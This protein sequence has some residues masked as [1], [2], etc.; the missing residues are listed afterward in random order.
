M[1]H[2][3]ATTTKH[4]FKWNDITELPCYYNSPD[5]EFSFISFR[6]YKFDKRITVVALPFFYMD[7][8]GSAGETITLDEETSRHVAQV[9]R[10]KAGEEIHLTDGKGSLFTTE[11]VINDKKKCQ[12]RIKTITHDPPSTR[13]ISMGISLVKNS[14]RFEWLLEKVT[15]IGI[16]EI[17]PLICSRTEKQKFRRERMQGIVVSAMLQSQQCW[18]PILHE[19]VSF[20]TIVLQA[21]HQQK[22][23]AHCLNENRSNLASMANTAINSQIILIGPEGDF[24]PTEIELAMQNHFIPVTIGKTR[25]RTETAGVV[26]AAILKLKE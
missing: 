19:P 17:I 10:R 12:V 16:R 8:P 20:E 7:Q 9:L 15:E 3:I 25:L 21:E 13:I 1:K 14:S 26:S 6:I 23:I 18:L 11:I 5:G 22:F 2:P 4:R 24:T